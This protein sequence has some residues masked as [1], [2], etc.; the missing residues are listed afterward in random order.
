MT[1][2]VPRP[3]AP[4]S[5]PASAKWWGNCWIPT[6][7][8]LWWNWAVEPKRM[9]SGWPMCD[10]LWS[11]WMNPKPCWPK[12]AAKM[13]LGCVEWVRGDLTCLPWASASFD[14]GLMHVTLEFVDH[15][16]E[17]LKAAMRIIKPGGRLVLGLIHGA[18]PWARH[19]RTRGQA[20]PTS[21]YHGAHFWTLSALT[22]LMAKRPSKVRGG[23]YIGPGECTVEQAWAWESRYC[24]V[25]S[26]ADA[27]FLAVRYDKP[28]IAAKEANRP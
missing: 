13:S 8:S 11:V 22:T 4:W 2:F 20:D 14:A 6:R 5:M 3:S 9:S 24:A 16:E 26:L 23:L 7:E 17:A 19:Y 15:P 21:V 18:G 12:P 25:R 1:R 10:V 27:G 28:A